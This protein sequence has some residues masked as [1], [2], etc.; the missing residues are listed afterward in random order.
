M[1]HYSTRTAD[2]SLYISR[3]SHSVQNRSSA[4][5]NQIARILTAISM[6][7]LLLFAFG[8]VKM[9]A[10]G[11]TRPMNGTLISPPPNRIFV[12]NQSGDEYNAWFSTNSTLFLSDTDLAPI[13]KAMDSR[14]TNG[15]EVYFEKGTYL[16]SKQ[17]RITHQD[18][19]FS[20]ELGTIVDFMTPN[21]M[22]LNDSTSGVLILADGV[23]VQGFT[24]QNCNMAGIKTKDTNDV[25]IAGNQIIN[26][27]TGIVLESANNVVVDSN[28]VVLTQGDG[29]YITGDQ[30]TNKSSNH[31]LVANN[32]IQYIGDTGIDVSVGTSNITY[33]FVDLINN[34]VEWYNDASRSFTSARAGITVSIPVTNFTIQGNIINN[35][36]RGMYANGFNGTISRNTITNFSSGCGIWAYEGNFTDSNVTVHGNSIYSTSALWG[37]STNK[38]WTITYNRIT[39]SGRFGN[40]AIN[41]PN[42]IKQNNSLYS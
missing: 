8:A 25:V 20:A 15:G 42:A 40:S 28:R 3:G 32:E 17:W 2:V 33:S 31:I 29:I 27:W 12:V 22:N 23:T 26:S 18:T 7:A 41:A 38:A 14:L 13:E 21:P 24:F 10:T 19:V 5:I 4:N 39:V 30:S 9:T 36:K 6:F 34:T 11:V 16:S 35:M 37:I 1:I